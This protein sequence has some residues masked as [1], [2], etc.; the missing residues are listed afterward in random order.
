MIP[1]P[2][3][4]PP[5]P[6]RNVFWALMLGILVAPA[7]GGTL[8]LAV[9][10]FVGAYR[11]NQLST[12]VAWPSFFLIPFLVGLVAAW[13]WRRLNRSVAIS[14]LDA[15]WIL[16]VS[17]LAAAIILREGV[18]CLIIVSPLVYVF[19]FTGILV[20]RLV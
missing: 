15:F 6:P 20:G 10:W 4:P 8:L 17:L 7:I 5:L 1:L 11:E 2:D 13:F 14:F 12:L 16:L 9:T 19:L 3:T 18:V